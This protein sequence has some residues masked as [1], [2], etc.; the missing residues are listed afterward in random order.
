MR[1]YHRQMLLAH[2]L[3]L[4]TLIGPRHVLTAGHCVHTGGSG[5]QWFSQPNLDFTLFRRPG[6]DGTSIIQRT[7]KADHAIAAKGWLYNRDSEDDYALII[8]QEDTSQGSMSF[9]W[10]TGLRK[11]WGINIDG[12]PSNKALG[13]MWHSFGSIHARL[14]VRL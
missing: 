1:F 2:L 12:F 8:L 6:I 9:G 14:V 4:G 11:G 3:I 13:T 7:F 10:Y 5:G